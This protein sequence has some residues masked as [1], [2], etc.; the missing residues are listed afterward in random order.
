VSF[1][2]IIIS[3]LIITNQIIFIL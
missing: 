2:F 3:Y 1:Y